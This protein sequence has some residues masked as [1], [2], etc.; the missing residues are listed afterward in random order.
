MEYWQLRKKRWFL[1]WRRFRGAPCRCW[2]WK[3]W[4]S[5]IFR[6]P[7]KTVEQGAKPFKF[8]NPHTKGE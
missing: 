2:F 7:P 8:D 1:A 3:S 5:L 6:G 4:W